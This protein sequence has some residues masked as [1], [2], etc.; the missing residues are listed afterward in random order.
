MGILG[1][2]LPPHTDWLE[3]L[4]PM[5]DWRL[6]QG[7]NI[8]IKASIFFTKKIII[9]INPKLSN[10]VVSVWPKNFTSI[11]MHYLEIIDFLIIIIK[12]LYLVLA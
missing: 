1:E 3:R 7:Y 4:E 8:T 5:L 10:K 9:I 12:N 6:T 11:Q 2:G